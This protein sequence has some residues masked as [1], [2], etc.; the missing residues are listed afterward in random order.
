M[1]APMKKQLFRSFFLVT[2]LS[3][4]SIYGVAIQTNNQ[5]LT[6]VG[7]KAITVLDIKKEMDRQIY[8][9]DKKIFTDVQ[10]LG[11][12]YYHH[13]KSVLNKMTQDEIYLLEA[14]EMKYEIASH[15]ITQKVTELFGENEIETYKFL[16]ITAE[17]ATAF[18]KRE[19]MS[20]HLSWF[21][22]WSK[23]LMEATPASVVEAYTEYVAD[24]AKKDTWTYQALFVK[25]SD[26]KAVVKTSNNITALLKD[27]KY[28]NFSLILDSINTDNKAVKVGV[29]KDI[30]LKTSELSPTLLSVLETLDEGMI[31]DVITGSRAGSY[32]G[33]ILQL[34]KHTK[35]KIPALA[36]ISEN[37]KNSIVN[38]TSERVSNECFA[39]LY[40]KYD[41]DGLYGSLLDK[42]TLEP[43]TLAND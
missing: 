26:E 4:S 24:L 16:S 32:T 33:K 34:K 8:M 28:Q 37:I 27:G 19:M 5:I 40:K 25:G 17:Q 18:G 1:I 42:T 39:K 35:E 23:S 13:W 6:R 20:S 3:V 43:F 10:A 2:L 12:Y 31:S 30:T 15:D 14:K 29:S 38:K 36:D 41:V 11:S 22:I 21:K 7:S 9:S